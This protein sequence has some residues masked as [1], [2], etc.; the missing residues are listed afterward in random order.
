MR[1]LEFNRAFR[2]FTV[3]S[4]RDI[5]SLDPNFHRRRLNE[6]QEKGYIRKVIKGFYIFGDVSL[7]ESVLFE[8]AN[9]I[10][11]PSY[12][13]L[14]TALSYYNLI[15]EAVFGVTSV[16]TR[17]TN[18]FSTPIAG[19]SYRSLKTSLF[20]GYD[21]VEIGGHRFRIACIEKAVI[22]FLYL[23]PQIDKERDFE[24]IRLNA[25]I[26]H[27]KVSVERLVDSLDRI[28]SKILETRAR[29]LL[30]FV[31]NA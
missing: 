1:F 20:F 2:A 23:N 7:N 22:D 4:L 9:R 18:K 12:V 29:A 15:P 10:Y 5:R 14:D 17:R 19:F 24:Y 16:S 13:S 31:R 11:A 21:L 26:F 30:E 28:K 3:F 6:W 27:E 8:I 25:D